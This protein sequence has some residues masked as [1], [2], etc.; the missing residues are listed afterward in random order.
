M[1]GTE[2]LSA[3]ST[4]EGTC[5][6]RFVHEPLVKASGSVRARFGNSDG[7]VREFESRKPRAKRFRNAVH[8]VHVVRTK[9][10]R[11]ADKTSTSFTMQS[12]GV[13]S[14]ADATGTTGHDGPSP[15]GVTGYEHCAVHGSIPYDEAR[16]R[17]D[18]HTYTA[19]AKAAKPKRIHVQLP[20]GNHHERWCRPFDQDTVRRG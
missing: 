3:C 12:P 15:E 7:L 17:V 14:E 9:A 4:E 16:R 5:A 19:R 13:K 18:T 8:G 20:M 1:V 11:S 10:S 2:T 6:R